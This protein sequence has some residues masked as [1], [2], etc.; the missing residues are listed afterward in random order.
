[1]TPLRLLL[2]EDMEDDEIL[3]LRSL[4][5]SGYQVEHQRVEC[6][7][8]M[9]RAL[10][11]H[12][13]D[14]IISDY[15]LPQFS[16][17]AALEVYHQVGKDLP[18]LIV[19]GTVG[20][21]TAVTAL[22]SGA[23]D[24]LIKGKYSRLGPAIE[25]ELKEAGERRARRQAEFALLESQR[26]FRSLIENS[27]D[28]ITVIGVDG[29]ITYASPSLQTVLGYDPER[30]LGKALEEFAHPAD[31]ELIRSVLAELLRC[32]G[33]SRTVEFRL[34]DCHGSWLVLE[35]IGKS[36]V[37]DPVV[38]GIVVNSRDVTQRKAAESRLKAANEELRAA[39]QQ[40]VRRE[41][42]TALGE[43]ASGIAHDFNNALSSI[44]GFS[45]A[46]L[47]YP[48]I[49]ED[50]E[51]TLELVRMIN[52]SAQ[53]G[54]QVVERLGEFYRTRERPE[55]L[56]LLDLNMIV[57]QAVRLTQ[58][59]WKGQA[60]SAGVQI[61]V[62]IEPGQIPKAHANAA[63]L[64]QALTNLIFN[65]T[66][67]MPEGGR[68]T[69]R[70]LPRPESDE[71]CLEI[72]DTGT[73]MSEA[74]RSRCLEPFFTTK[75]QKGTGMGLAMVYGIIRRHSGMI[76]VDSKLG[77]GTT[78]RIILPVQGP[79]PQEQDDVAVAPELENAAL[80]VL[81]V[82]EEP[83]V[84]TVVT[85]FLASDGHESELANSGRAALEKIRENL[86]AETP[87]NVIIAA[88]STPE[89]SGEQLALAAKELVPHT[90][91]ILMS[92]V[93]DGAALSG[94]DVMVTKPFTLETFRRA[95]AQAV[96]SVERQSDMEQ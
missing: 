92:G 48:D 12:D 49:L 87:Y 31:R 57:D 71:V 34:K 65:A 4:R 76:E 80:R 63:E 41:R 19:S 20:E 5:K 81:V 90:P 37:N 66:D 50:H 53:D 9:R 86:Q 47:M 61:E 45:E 44:L 58:P 32:D 55:D 84:R 42:L 13:W 95:L 2:V 72:S 89:I 28:I 26:R 75:G 27:L 79:A 23:H 33:E 15:N 7:E 64:R 93:N 94:V 3:L 11:S 6:A 68:L 39:Q 35:A 67:A 22:R 83:F 29:R 62:A 38:G 88:R 16:A 24:F 77:E 1:M 43:M 85:T 82:E 30:A 91:V 36:M 60:R 74:T 96:L 70:T 10:E 54:A 78:F 14:L 52:V 8:E 25:R 73:G 59:R 46:L 17:L 18:F 51:Q 69:L 56:E 40:L 21:E